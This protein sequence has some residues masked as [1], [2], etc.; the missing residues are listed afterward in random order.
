MFASCCPLFS[1]SI[2]F[3]SRFSAWISINTIAQVTPTSRQLWDVW[4]IWP[5]VIYSVL[6][7]TSSTSELIYTHQTT[8]G[9][10]SPNTK[11]CQNESLLWFYCVRIPKVH[12]FADSFL[13]DFWRLL[14]MPLDFSSADV[15][16]VWLIHM[17]F[18]RKS[19]TGDLPF[20]RGP[21]WILMQHTNITFG[22]KIKLEIHHVV[23]SMLA[24][25]KETIYLYLS[26]HRIFH[27]KKYTNLPF[28]KSI[29]YIFS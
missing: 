18:L 11:I 21:I 27:E 20:F 12:V 19:H 28:P 15:A 23:A 7:R 24:E 9:Q 2:R 8:P 6:C 13:G 16:D 17:I 14:I 29:N 3:F 26:I 22:N 10:W 1:L 25:S 5:A 4:K